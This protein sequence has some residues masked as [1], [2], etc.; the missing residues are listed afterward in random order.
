MNTLSSVLPLDAAISAAAR[1]AVRLFKSVLGKYSVQSGVAVE[2]PV[3]LRANCEC[4]SHDS[5]LGLSQNWS[6][7]A[8]LAGFRP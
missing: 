8:A 4:P 6:P 1:A 5:E 3:C 7:N 2:R